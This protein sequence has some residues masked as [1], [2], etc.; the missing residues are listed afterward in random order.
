MTAL[1]TRKPAMEPESRIRSAS[2]S[3][4][5][6]ASTPARYRGTRCSDFTGRRS[7]V[8]LEQRLTDYFKGRQFVELIRG[9]G[10][11]KYCH[12]N[13]RSLL[14]DIYDLCREDT[15]QAS[16]LFSAVHA[17]AT[18]QNCRDALV[19]GLIPPWIVVQR[20]QSQLLIPPTGSHP[21]Q[22]E[23]FRLTWDNKEFNLAEI[24]KSMQFNR[25]HVMNPNGIST[26]STPS[27]IVKTG[28]SADYGNS[29]VYGYSGQQHRRVPSSKRDALMVPAAEFDAPEIPSLVL[30][31]RVSLAVMQ[32]SD[33]ATLRVNQ[34]HRT[35]H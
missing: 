19:S 16:H 14:T 1:T 29:T 4:A 7:F 31:C 15:S 34:R 6:G 2:A 8:P 27:F 5:S 21:H 33:G 13:S 22:D 26:Q 23:T 11:T 30:R 24:K 32:V 20:S 35:D 18:K 3:A 28:D 10:S 12:M 25:H 9:T 17:L